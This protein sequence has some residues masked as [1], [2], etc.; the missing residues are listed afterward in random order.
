[1]SV[2][3]MHEVMVQIKLLATKCTK[4]QFSSKEGEMGSPLS[5]MTHFHLAQLKS[6]ILELSD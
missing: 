2:L 6:A 1:M 3:R 4:G 5:I